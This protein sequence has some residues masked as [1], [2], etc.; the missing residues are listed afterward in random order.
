MLRVHL[1]MP[2]QTLFGGWA[3]L[4]IMIF[5][6][7]HF[8]AILGFP[9]SWTFSYVLLSLSLACKYAHEHVLLD[10]CFCWHLAFLPRLRD[11]VKEKYRIVYEDTLSE[12]KSSIFMTFLLVFFW[13]YFSGPQ[14]IPR[15]PALQSALQTLARA[16]VGVVYDNL[17]ALVVL[18][19]VHYSW[20]YWFIQHI[21]SWQNDVFLVGLTCIKG[22]YAQLYII[23]SLLLLGW[24]GHSLLI[25]PDFL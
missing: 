17:A 22:F 18:W 2:D 4:C 8:V 5:L 16:P 21:S 11:E 12:T 9:L 23:W 6:D 15:E 13:C 19:I 25:F 10:T 3:F 7:D 20:L 24:L 1:S 14:Q